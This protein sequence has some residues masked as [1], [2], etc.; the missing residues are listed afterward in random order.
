MAGFVLT[1]NASAGLVGSGA[2]ESPGRSGTGD[3]EVDSPEPRWT[4]WARQ[5]PH[6]LSHVSREVLAYSAAIGAVGLGRASRAALERWAFFPR[7]EAHGSA[8]GILTDGTFLAFGNGLCG[9]DI[10]LF[11]SLVHRD[12]VLFVGGRPRV[13]AVWLS[14]SAA[15]RPPNRPAPAAQ[16]PSPVRRDRPAHRPTVFRDSADNP[17]KQADEALSAGRGV[18]YVLPRGLRC[19]RQVW[20]QV[21]S[22]V[23]RLLAS[24]PAA[25]AAVW[26]L[27]VVY[28]VSPIHVL[29]SRLLP[30]RS[31]TRFLA[32]VRAATWTGPPSVFIP[33][34]VA[35]SE[36]QV[37]AE[38][39]ST[40]IGSRIGDVW[41]DAQEKAQ[42]AIPRW[43]PFA[44]WPG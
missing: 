27:P 30:R 29:A 28:Q 1:G 21:G 31:I 43:R 25:S 39:S 12:D 8:S 20:D 15:R 22:I 4:L 2:S 26:V 24:R 37:A 5:R 34:P 14:G 3:L 41:L 10:P 13:R 18:V 40:D 33:Q 23:E 32:Q 17:V 11:G 42:A 44:R 36:L 6:S 7:V 38:A 35:V 16:G 9:L 19:D